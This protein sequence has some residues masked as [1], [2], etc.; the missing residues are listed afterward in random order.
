MSRIFTSQGFEITGSE[1][2]DL[3]TDHEP[4]GLRMVWASLSLWVGSEHFCLRDGVGLATAWV[5]QAPG[6]EGR[7]SR[8]L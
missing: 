1:V 5:D 8:G 3:W 2:L 4:A 7:A 6:R